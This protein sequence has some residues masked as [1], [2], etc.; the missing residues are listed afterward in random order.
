MKRDISLL[1][2]DD[3]PASSFNM[4][5]LREFRV[6]GHIFFSFLFHSVV[7]A[8]VLKNITLSLPEGTSD[9]GIPGLLCP[10]TRGKDVVSFYLFNY[11][12][13]AVTVLRRPGER[14]IDFAVAVIGSLFF[15]TIGLHRGVEALLSSSMLSRC[16][17]TRAAQAGAL[18]M[19]IRSPDWRPMERDEVPNAVLHQKSNSDHLEG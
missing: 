10:P 19:L 12:V 5:S 15:P 11:I 16:D 9:H 8:Y 2:P 1:H 3:S 13:H 17:L 4:M 18:C 14:F 7:T 6:W